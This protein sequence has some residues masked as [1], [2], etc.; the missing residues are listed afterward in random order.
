MK[1]Q[2]K[3]IPISKAQESLDQALSLSPAD[4]A[5]YKAVEFAGEGAGSF[6]LGSRL[7]L[8]NMAAEMGAKNGYFAPDE[9]VLDFLA[10]HA[11]DSFEP[12]FSDPDARYECVL[13][14]DLTLL[15]PQVACPHTVIMSGLFLKFLGLAFIKRSSALAQMVG[16]RI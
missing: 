8:A 5:N 9:K 11:R 14:Y 1:T 12:V 7:V 16:L 4:R 15:E 10:E 2:N 3:T 13:D 6:S